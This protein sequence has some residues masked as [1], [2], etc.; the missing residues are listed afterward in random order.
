MNG[1][2][3]NKTFVSSDCMAL[4][5]D[6][7][8]SED[9][10]DWVRPEQVVSALP[11]VT[12]A[13]HYSRNHMRIKR[14]KPAR[15]KFHLM[16]AMDP[17]GDFKEYRAM[18]HRLAE[19]L[20]FVDP[21]ALDAARFFYGTEDPL[22]EFFLGDKTLNALLGDAEADFD[23]G[24]PGGTYGEQVITEGKRNATL[25]LRAGKIVK[26]FGYTE[27]AHEIF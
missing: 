6:N 15:P 5:F 11:G 19:L 3:S 7:D 12:V 24:M 8:H 16:I 10:A 13:V 20:P 26:R 9:P 17:V 22:V 14:G 2:R 18:K 27:E 21:N 4:E 1:Y 25:S 23:L